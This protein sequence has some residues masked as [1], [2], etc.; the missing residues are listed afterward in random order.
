MITRNVI[1][2]VE[3][4]ITETADTIWS[5]NAQ[6]QLTVLSCLDK[7]FFQIP[8]DGE[9]QLACMFNAL[10]QQLSPEKQKHVKHFIKALHQYLVEE[11]N[12]EIEEG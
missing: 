2:K 1:V 10:R 4:T 6:D 8:T 9:D 12:S 5:M 7:R 3:P 11:D